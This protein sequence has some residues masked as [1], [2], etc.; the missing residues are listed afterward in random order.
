MQKLARPVVRAM[1]R[2]SGWPKTKRTPSPISLRRSL[3]GRGLGCFLG[4]PDALEEE[5][6]EQVA[7]GVDDDRELRPDEL[8]ESAADPGTGHVRGGTDRLQGAVAGHELVTGQDLREV[9]LV[10]DV[11]EHG[12]HAGHE[13]DHVELDHGQGADEGG[14]GDAGHGHG[15]Q[16]VRADHQ[17]TLAHPVGER[18]G[19]QAHEQEGGGLRGGQEAHLEGGSV[20]FEDGHQR[21]RHQGHLCTELSGGGSR[22]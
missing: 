5:G 10:R 13:S 3:R 15:A 11:E 19:G 12:G 16:Q 1:T 22:E 4:P 18:S 17:G 9:A 20:E 7:D 8:D 2:S 14:S 21:Q 6:G